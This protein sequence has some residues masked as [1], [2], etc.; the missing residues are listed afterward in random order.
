[1]NARDKS[2]LA[3]VKWG[4]FMVRTISGVKLKT[5]G[6]KEN[7]PKDVPVLFVGNHRSYFDVVIA[8]T[9][10]DR[11]TGFISK[12][13]IK[14]IPFLSWW[15]YFVKCLFLD[16]SSAKAGFKTIMD[17][18]E[19]VKNGISIFIYPEGTRS[20]NGKLLEFK[21]GSMR[22]AERS[23]CPIIPVSFK[24]T[25]EIFEKHMP[26][27]KSTEVEVKFGEP[28]YPDKL[29]KDEKKVLNET[30]RNKIAEMLGEELEDSGI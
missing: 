17:A 21:A 22:I 20:R 24:N 3:F 14:R 4:L 9:L 5:S 25:E 10:V 6:Y 26:F 30:V 28:I 15:M 23:G 8:Y 29:S 11:P 13:E 1:M 7:V 2:S 19:Y 12:Q 16:R 18:I 27:I